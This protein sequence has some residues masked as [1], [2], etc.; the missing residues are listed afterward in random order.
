MIRMFW[1]PPVDAGAP[2]NACEVVMPPNILRFAAQ[3]IP[4]ITT[5]TTAATAVT[6]C[7]KITSRRFDDRLG[8]RWRGG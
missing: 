7:A 2:S 1:S 3:A 6:N 5:M 8:R 4:V